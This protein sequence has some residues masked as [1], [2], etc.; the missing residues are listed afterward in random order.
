MKYFSTKPEDWERDPNMNRSIR[1]PGH[2]EYASTLGLGVYDLEED[3][4]HG[5]DGMSETHGQQL[6]PD[7]R[8]R[9]G[10]WPDLARA[11]RPSAQAAA[12]SKLYLSPRRRRVWSTRASRRP[13]RRI[14][15][16]VSGG[17]QPRGP[18]PAERGAGHQRSVDRLERLAVRARHPQGELRESAR[19][20][21]AAG[22]GRSVRLQRRRHPQ[23]RSGGSSTSSARCCAS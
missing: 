20:L 16:V 10:G 6:P 21:R 8:V 7:L 1:E 18:I 13:R 4:S 15:G 23:S 12:A 19:R 9:C 2:I 5:T 11:R 3:R 14:R 22:R 17:P